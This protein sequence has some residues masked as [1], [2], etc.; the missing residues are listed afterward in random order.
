MQP[1]P[2][3]HSQTA[4]KP[5]PLDLASLAA[6]FLLDDIQAAELLGISAGTLSVWRS[7]GRY[8]LPYVKIGR[9]VKYKAGDLRDF[10]ERR[11][12]LH[13]GQGAA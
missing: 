6:S 2:T 5:T 11:T 1:Q 12:R 7:V 4:Q 13:T 3:Q 9:R 8:S 10:I